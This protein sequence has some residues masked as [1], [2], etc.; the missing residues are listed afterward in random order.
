MTGVVCD[1]RSQVATFFPPVPLKVGKVINWVQFDS[2]FKYG[3]G[4][5]VEDECAGWSQYG[6]ACIR[7]CPECK[8]ASLNV[9]GAG[10]V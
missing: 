6:K 8:Q 3:Y 10:N 4:E 9:P 7:H 5:A 2:W 1:I